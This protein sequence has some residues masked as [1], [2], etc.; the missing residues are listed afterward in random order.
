[1]ESTEISGRPRDDENI[2]YMPVPRRLL[3]AFYRALATALT[4]A[5]N[6]D[7][8]SWPGAVAS[9]KR[10]LIDLIIQVA[11]GMGADRHP[12]SLTEL[13][14]AYIQAFP[15]IGKGTTRGS[16]DATVN[17]HCINMRS[18]FPDTND[19]HKQ[20]YWLMRPVFKRVARARYMLLSAEEIAW[21]KERAAAD[22]PVI[23][24]D[25]YDV[26]AQMG[27]PA[28]EAGEGERDGEA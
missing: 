3:P 19:K 10:R 18:R 22:D 13:H 4:E 25:E 20:A 27:G 24:A 14:E 28:D 11:Y 7:L 26:R 8:R 21:F 15:G 5:T 1:M 2:I 23:F 16:F 17:Y 6:D 12:V 9:G